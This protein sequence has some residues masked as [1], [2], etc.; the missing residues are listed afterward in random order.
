M[1]MK[2]L[3]SI[4]FILCTLVV[5]GSA[6]VP[7][8]HAVCDPAVQSCAPTDPAPSS[9]PAPASNPAPPSTPGTSGSGGTA[10]QTTAK[11]EAGP[12][13]AEMDSGMAYVMN[14]IMTLFAWL[15]G[16]AAITLDNAVLYTVVTM[17]DVVKNLTAVGIAWRV[18]RDIGNIMLIFGFLAVGISTI[19]NT[20]LY[21]WSTK[22]LPMLLISAVMLNFSL[23]ITEAVIDTG[24]LFATQIYTQ[25]NGG[26][27]AGQKGIEDITTEG[28]S[29]KI[30]SQLRLTKI[31]NDAR[32]DG[33]VLTTSNSFVIGFMSIILFMVLAFTMFSL[34]FVLLSR[35]VILL[36]VI[37]I[38]PVGLAVYAIP[39]MKGMSDLWKD[40][41]FT[42]TIT[43]PV[44]LLMLYVALIVI[45]DTAFLT[46]FGVNDAAS[47]TDF[48][49]G[50]KW[51]GFAGL[52]LSFIVAI[53]LLLGVSILAKKL[54]AR[55]AE[56]AA[57]WGAKLSGATLLAAGAGWAGRQSAGRIG[58]GLSKYRV[59]KFFGAE[60]LAKGSY[61]FRNTGASKTL[62]GYG[63][64]LGKGSSSNFS[65]LAKDKAEKDKKAEKARN[66]NENKAAAQQAAQDS[67]EAQ[68]AYNESEAAHATAEAEHAKQQAEVASIEAEYNRVRTPENFQKLEEARGKLAT[69]EAALKAAKERRNNARTAHTSKAEAARV[70]K[71]EMQKAKTEAEL[72]D[73]RAELKKTKDKV[74]GGGEKKEKKEEKKEETKT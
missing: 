24:N 68:K 59:A 23:F 11:P 32:T 28:I 38:S 2:K 8:V 46:G 7:V 18:L 53:G 41:L 66:E 67:A 25:I 48:I 33:K 21:G 51:A 35:F 43:A 22:M 15:L 52:I 70:A 19:L 44:L 9:N 29:Q 27:P 6:F 61:D 5:S 31:Y 12:S 73:I 16:I 40:N 60:K 74:E 36:F 3:L 34:A 37:I 71:E 50:G 1:H 26:K 63:M 13:T 56:G 30:M 57:N 14:K 55:G 39:K 65:K 54:S 17:G 47:L 20:D 64:P 72:E 4:G 45:T 62:A 42:Q 58:Q 69:N 49:Q 10:A